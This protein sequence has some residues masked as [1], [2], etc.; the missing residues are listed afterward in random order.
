M[1]ISINGVLVRNEEASISPFDHG[2]MYGLGAFETF[3]TYD[4]HPF[5]LS[6]HVDR[7]N[8]AMD[9]LNI[10]RLFTLEEVQTMTAD[11]L[12]KNGCSDAY[13]R[14]N[15]SAGIGEIGLQTTAYKDPTVIVYGKPLG[16][17]PAVEKELVLLKTRRNTPEG[18]ERIKSHHYLNSILGKRELTDPLHQEGLFLTQDGDIA[19]GCVSNVFWMND[20]VLF[21]P[22]VS[23]GILN[24]ITRQFVLALAGTLN[25]QT[26]SGY[27]KKEDLLQADEIFLTNSIQEIVP[28]TRFAQKDYPG[29]DGKTAKLLQSR[30]DTYKYSLLSIKEWK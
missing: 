1:Y 11:L 21:T 25:I 13:I 15:V 23:T 30:Y 14:F 16:S 9:Q 7:L 4:G 12:V 17:A 26:T 28:V 10:N 20:G 6:D 2:F 19:E 18:S 5:L 29:K 22:A 8:A 24:G 27:Y 3:R